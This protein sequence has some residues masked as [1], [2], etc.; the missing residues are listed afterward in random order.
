MQEPAIKAIKI[1]FK[2]KNLQLKHHDNN[3]TE[4]DDYIK[5]EEIETIYA[6]Q[7]D[8]KTCARS[9]KGVGGECNK[10]KRRQYYWTSSLL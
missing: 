9:E 4:N 6:Y 2:S 5:Y 3:S 7:I 10:E 1:N 8:G